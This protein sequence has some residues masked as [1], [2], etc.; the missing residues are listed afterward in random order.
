ME[1]KR[2]FIQNFA[3]F[4]ANNGGGTINIV[5]DEAGNEIGFEVSGK[6]TTFGVRNVNGYIFTRESYDKFVDDYYSKNN[7][8][9][10]LNIKHIDS[11]FQHVAGYVKSMTKTT[12]G[13]V[14][15]AFVPK[16]V[17]AYNWIK[18]AIKDGVLQGFSNAGWVTDAIYDEN[19][20]TITVNEFALMHVALVEIPAD[21]EAKFEVK[22]TV[23]SGF[24]KESQKT[25]KNEDWESLV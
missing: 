15:T 10:P 18:N 1:K 6:L 25:E 5:T 20:D 3:R 9:I 22:N 16:W 17:Y 7:F 14:M 23:F 21:V 19:E 12:D 2:Q 11:D 8:N 13:I 4:T 24:E